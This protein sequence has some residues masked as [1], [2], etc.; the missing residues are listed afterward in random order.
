MPV[1]T[2]KRR[3]AAPLVGR[4]EC[5]PLCE[6]DEAANHRLSADVGEGRRSPG[7]QA[8]EHVNRGVRR[9]GASSPRLRD[10]RDKECPATRM[11]ESSRD[12]LDAAAISIGFD[13]GGTL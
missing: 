9:G 4:T 2:C 1:S 8:I 3:P 13:D 10:V 7:Q 12:R 6:F 11:C 5:V